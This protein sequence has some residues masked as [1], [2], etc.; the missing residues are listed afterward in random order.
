MV[1]LTCKACWSLLRSWWLG[2]C[3][4]SPLK[5]HLAPAACKLSTCRRPVCRAAAI[6]F[7]LS[8]PSRE[9]T[10]GSSPSLAASPASASCQWLRRMFALTSGPC[11]WA[12]ACPR[13][14]RKQ[15]GVRANSAASDKIFFKLDFSN[16]S[17]CVRREV[18]LFQARKQFPFWHGGAHGVV[19]DLTCPALVEASGLQPTLCNARRLKPSADSAWELVEPKV[20]AGIAESSFLLLP[21]SMR[22]WSRLWCCCRGWCSCC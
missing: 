22:M 11:K 2:D 17:N 8:L 4:P 19:L 10:S 16:S 13:A 7:W 1:F 3:G 21:S 14:Q 18:V 15:H 5:R 6:I 20:A 9:G 12:S